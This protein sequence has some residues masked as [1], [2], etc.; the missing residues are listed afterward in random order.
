MEETRDVLG[1]A[2]ARL[3]LSA[4]YLSRGNLRAAL[5]YLHGLPAE[6]ERL[7]DV[8][9]LEAALNNLRVLNEVSSRWLSRARRA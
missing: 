1:H 7:G 3:N 9:S 5:R 6:L 2:R 8:V 4:I